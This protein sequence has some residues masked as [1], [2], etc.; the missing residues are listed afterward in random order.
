MK[1]VNWEVDAVIATIPPTT[2]IEIAAGEPEVGDRVRCI[3]TG[4]HFRVARLALVSG[5]GYA[6]GMRGVVLEC[7]DEIDLEGLRA[8]VHLVG[9]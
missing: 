4:Q 6:N 7:T 2:I 8:G 9:E 5:L 1:Q 3:E